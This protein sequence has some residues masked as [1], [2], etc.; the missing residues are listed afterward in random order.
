MSEDKVPDKVFLVEGGNTIAFSGSEQLPEYSKS[1]FLLYI[2]FLV[3]T[4][5]TDQQLGNIKFSIPGMPKAYYNPK[6][7]NWNNK[8]WKE[9]E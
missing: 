3:A 4:G 8:P 1:W 7:N 9:K 5:V 2:G 6:T